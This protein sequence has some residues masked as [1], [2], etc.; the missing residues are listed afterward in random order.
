MPSRPPTSSTLDPRPATWAVWRR[1]W[2]QPLAS[3]LRAA[4][5][6]GLSGLAGFSTLHHA[7]RPSCS[8]TQTSTFLD[9]PEED[10]TSSL[11]SRFPTFGSFF[12]GFSA[13][14][15]TTHSPFRRLHETSKP[16]TA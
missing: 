3:P 15:R 11:G 13:Y 6:L 8:A 4:A 10:S 16:F 5:L 7:T 9:G 14:S 12:L 1:L 2:N